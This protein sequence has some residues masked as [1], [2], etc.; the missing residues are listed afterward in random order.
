V[1]A[2]LVIALAVISLPALACGQVTEISDYYHEDLADPMP[3]GN[4][5]EYDA[6]SEAKRIA[7]SEEKQQGVVA[8][9]EKKAYSKA[10]AE[11]PVPKKKAP[12]A[13]TKPKATKK[14]KSA[15]KP[16]GKKNAPS[17]EQKDKAS[18]FAAVQSVKAKQFAKKYFG[19]VSNPT[20]K[21]TELGESEDEGFGFFSTAFNMPTFA[22]GHAVQQP[23][24]MGS[25]GGEEDLGESAA[26]SP[27]GHPYRACTAKQE[28]S[29]VAC[30]IYGPSHQ[31]CNRALEYE[32]AACKVFNT[33]LGESTK[34]STEVVKKA[35]NKRSDPAALMNLVPTWKAA[36]F[37]LPGQSHH[38]KHSR[39]QA[40]Y[41]GCILSMHFNTNSDVCGRKQCKRKHRKIVIGSNGKQMC[42][43]SR[44][45][46]KKLPSPMLTTWSNAQK[47]FCKYSKGC[48]ASY[49]YSPPIHFDRRTGKLRAP[50]YKWVHNKMVDVKLRSGKT[51][52]ARVS[53][54]T[55]LEKAVW[56]EKISPP[57]VENGKIKDK[58]CVDFKAC[59]MK[60]A[61]LTGI[62]DRSSARPRWFNARTLAS[63]K[64]ST[65]FMKQVTKKMLRIVDIL[66]PKV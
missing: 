52:S 10:E 38:E 57:V 50:G 47:E 55:A 35:L 39:R 49:C 24:A 36:H 53:I 31:M 17:A 63:F 16:T 11:V 1:R 6:L 61:R 20:G 5:I 34:P 29:V 9:K 59:S 41:N 12:K 8:K 13:T 7:A 51:V 33:D 14:P 62:L 21:P 18:K 4:Q 26:V 58:D 19:T 27:L 23:T 3:T 37:G 60:N 56:C 54:G 40:V 22:A 25:I 45:L 66:C 42:S 46:M 44:W 2:G 32:K 15:M 28:A 65:S 30:N 43:C 64:R 48:D